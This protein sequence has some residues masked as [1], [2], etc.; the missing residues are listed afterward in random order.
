MLPASTFYF[1]LFL[2]VP[3]VGLVLEH[4][5]EFYPRRNNDSMT[6]WSMV[7]E[8]TDSSDLRLSI[9]N[10]IFFQAS[11]IIPHAAPA[12]SIAF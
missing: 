10:L 7:Q 12:H 5:H 2:R 4:F 1:E 8:E 3:L 9:V 6:D 11:A